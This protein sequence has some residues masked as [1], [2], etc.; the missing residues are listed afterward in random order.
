MEE[1]ELKE[2]MLEK[3]EEFR[4][5]YKQHQKFEKDLE[6]FKEKSFLTEDEKL[7]EKELKKKKLALKDRMYFMMTEFRKSL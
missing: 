3:N 1:K 4:K 6:K 7:K 2:L 5:V